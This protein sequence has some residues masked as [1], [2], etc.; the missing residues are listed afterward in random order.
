MSLLDM[1]Q[2]QL[3]G[4]PSALADAGKGLLGKLLG[5]K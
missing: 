5:G 4:E 3:A 2:S 1:L